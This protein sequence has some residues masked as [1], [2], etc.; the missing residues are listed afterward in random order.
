MS[1]VPMKGAHSVPV[2]HVDFVSPYPWLAAHQ[3]DELQG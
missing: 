2:E 3:L 1:S